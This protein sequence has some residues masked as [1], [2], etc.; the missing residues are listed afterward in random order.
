[1]RGDGSYVKRTPEMHAATTDA[2]TDESQLH[3]DILA[4]CREHGWRAIHS[5][6]DRKTT[7]AK[8]DPDFVIFADRARVF[9][10]ECKS[11]TGKRTVDQIGCAMQLEKLG[12]DCSLVR[13]LA[14]FKEL[15]K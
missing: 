13:S 2:V 9:A 6:M 15:T 4:Y 1:M 3:D 5:R 14:E 8:G 11:R 7:T 12:H 10:I